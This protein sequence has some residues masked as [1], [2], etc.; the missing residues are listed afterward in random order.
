MTDTIKVEIVED[1][2]EE[3][4]FKNLFNTFRNKHFHHRENTINKILELEE[5]KI[6]H[7]LLG[8]IYTSRNDDMI[9][10]SNA[11][12][13]IDN[14]YIE[15]DKFYGCI[16]ILD[17]HSGNKFKDFTDLLILRPVYK[18]YGLEFTPSGGLTITTK[19]E[20]LTFNIDLNQ[21][22]IYKKILNRK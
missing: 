14:I 3:Y 17:T 4:N 1:I 21:K 19:I 15:D 2:M 8:G 9:S 11:S 12:H 20:I 13:T 6:E 18:G 7:T 16:R 10:L 5:L 22:M